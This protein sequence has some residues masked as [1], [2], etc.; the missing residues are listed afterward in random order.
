MVLYDQWVME[1]IIKKI[2][3]FLEFNENANTNYQKLWDTE[4]T[5][6]RGKFIAMSA[7]IKR[8]ES[9]QINDLMLYLKLLEKQEQAKPKIS[10]RREIIKIRVKMNEIKTKKKKKIQRINESQSCFFEKINKI[11][12][13]LANLT[14]MRREKPKSVKSETKKK[15]YSK[16]QGNPGNHQRLL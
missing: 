10:R 5:V 11:D 7:Y 4:K 16:H 1:E 12:K 15:D 2:K 13:P 6:L 14:K 9:S 8:T 3:N